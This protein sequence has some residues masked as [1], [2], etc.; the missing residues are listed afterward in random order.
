MGLGQSSYKRL[1]SLV[2]ASFI[3]EVGGQSCV[4]IMILLV[5]RRLGF[6]FT[7]HPVRILPPP[8]RP[9]NFTLL[10]SSVF[11]AKSRTD[12]FNFF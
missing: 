6:A 5:R 8:R 3:L 12:S 11:Q 7:S 1:K 2:L 9:R 4:A 10:P